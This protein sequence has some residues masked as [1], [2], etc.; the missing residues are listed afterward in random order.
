MN[1]RVAL[2]LAIALALGRGAQAWAAPLGADAC[3]AMAVE[4][5]A[6]ARAARADV[7][8]IRAQADQV[9][10]ALST[11]ISVLTFV[12][13]IFSAKGG[14]GFDEPYQSDLGKWGP[15]GHADARIVKP[16]ATFGRYSA[17]V[18]AARARVGVEE[19]RARE[20]ANAVRLEVRRLYGLRLY[21]LSMKPNLENGKKILTEA[22]EKAGELYRKDTGEV[23]L[24]DLMRLQYGAGEI[25]RYLRIADDG[26]ELATAALKQSLGLPADTAVEFADDKLLPSDKPVPAL[27]VLVAAARRDRPEIGQIAHGKVATAAW[28]QAE[29][30][31]NLPV[32]FAAVAGQADWSPVRPTG[33]SGALYNLYNDYFVGAAVG[34]KLDIDFALAGA[35]A[36]EARAKA[37]WVVEN[38]ALAE[39][40]VPL[41]VRKARGDLIQHRDLA[42]VADGQV[43]AARKWMLFS[44][45][46]YAS[47]TGE[48]KDV[49]E[50]VAAYLLAKKA[51]YDHLLG[52]WQARAELE[53][54]T[55]AR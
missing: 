14:I 39:T 18:A 48:A 26:I 17:G 37:R 15:Y 40:G 25:A 35:K 3:A 30:K 1:R 31:A 9:A 2:T 43:T 53:Q 7:E 54:A 51:Y 13:P 22:I 33:F 23:T 16:L 28:E 11:K 46:A 36:A 50:G 41:Q 5:N 38:E 42:Q 12:A 29:R 45:A 21:A 47:G 10:A 27:G 4:Q 49:L 8:V 19:E 52:A 20:A 34:L 44:A 24:P 32:L 6:R 55:G